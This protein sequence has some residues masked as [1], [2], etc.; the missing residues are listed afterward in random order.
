MTYTVRDFL[1]ANLAQSRRTRDLEDHAARFT[2]QP[3]DATVASLRT[4]LADSIGIED[5]RRLHVLIS[6]L[7]HW[8]GASIPLTATL[9][10]EVN[11]ALTFSRASS[12]GEEVSAP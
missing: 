7:Y 10:A 6:H 5:Y 4:V 1:D 11:E 9:R 12:H 8:C 3:L 2:G